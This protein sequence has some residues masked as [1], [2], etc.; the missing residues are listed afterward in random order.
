MS[1]SRKSQEA[2]YLPYALSQK[3]LTVCPRAHGISDPL[4]FP[5]QTD[6]KHNENG[7]VNLL[8]LSLLLI[9]LVN[10][11]CKY[12]LLIIFGKGYSEQVAQP[13]TS[14][15]LATTFSNII[16]NKGN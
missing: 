5:V 10:K 14:S 4:K 7:D 2:H 15:S 9:G 12:V 8:R 11:S 6:T 1:T 3:F 13:S 16:S